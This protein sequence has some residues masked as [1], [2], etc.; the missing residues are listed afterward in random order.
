MRRRCPLFVGRGCEEHHETRSPATLTDAAGPLFATPLCHNPTVNLSRVPSQ[1]P[2]PTAAQGCN[3]ALKFALE[4]AALAAFAYWGTTLHG[5]AVSAL[6][7]VVAPLAMIVLWGKFA[8]PRAQHR[9]SRGIRIPF[10][11]A[12]F[13][14][15]AGALLAAGARVPAAGLTTLVLLNSVLLTRFDQW[16]G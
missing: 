1:G 8:A 13:A 11:L 2:A 3:L 6:A 4:L 14:L 12:V 16:D 9:L 7:T 5:T 10:E 15:A